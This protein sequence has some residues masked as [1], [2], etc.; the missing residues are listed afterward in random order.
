MSWPLFFINFIVILCTNQ[1]KY[2]ILITIVFSGIKCW[3]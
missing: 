3:K 2:D 1:R